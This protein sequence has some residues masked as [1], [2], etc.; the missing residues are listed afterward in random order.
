MESARSVP[1]SGRQFAPSRQRLR[2]K[3]RVRP[4]SAPPAPRGVLGLHMSEV[5]RR[6]S[7]GLLWAL[8]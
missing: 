5:I 2:A 4:R 3:F 8:A 7:Q 1:S 6:M